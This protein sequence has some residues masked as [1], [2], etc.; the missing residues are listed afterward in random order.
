[1]SLSRNTCGVRARGPILG[2][3]NCRSN[4][5]LYNKRRV[6][7]ASTTDPEPTSA[8]SF[9]FYLPKLPAKTPSVERNCVIVRHLI[10]TSI[11]ADYET[12]T[13]LQ[14][15]RSP[16]S[17]SYEVTQT[18]VA[19]YNARPVDLPPRRAARPSAQ[20]TCKTV[21]PDTQVTYLPA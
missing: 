6:A 18:P 13:D 11:P 12:D 7:Y 4:P 17:R 20:R 9:R 19:A 10:G 21:A 16:P 1:M 3:W 5:W 15:R 2:M 14:R 8:L